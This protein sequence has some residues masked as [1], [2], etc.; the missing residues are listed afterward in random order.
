MENE[1]IMK[2]SKCNKKL[3]QEEQLRY[4]LTPSW[5]DILDNIGEVTKTRPEWNLG[6]TIRYVSALKEGLKTIKNTTELKEQIEQGLPQHKETA[7]YLLQTVLTDI[8][9]EKILKP[10][11]FH[12]TKYDCKK[13][14][15]IYLQ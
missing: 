13:C 5:D 14:G 8:Y 4:T 3:I 11:A 2:C 6:L 1:L 10:K 15:L 12:Y 7:A 9:K